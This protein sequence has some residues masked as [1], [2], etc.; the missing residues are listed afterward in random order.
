MTV[1]PTTWNEE[2]SHTLDEFGWSLGSFSEEVHPFVRTRSR[3]ER[4]G[5][6]GSE[7][8]REGR[9]LRSKERVQAPARDRLND[10]KRD[11]CERRALSQ[12]AT[13]R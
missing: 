4:R 11:K 1:E 9:A 6:V 3:E 5:E 7:G 10:V 12:L 13:W 8:G 2:V